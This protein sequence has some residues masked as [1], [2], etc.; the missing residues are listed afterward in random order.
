MAKIENAIPAWPGWETVRLIG[1]GSFGAVYEIRK[2]VLGDTE[3]CALKHLSIPRDESE[4]LELRLEGQDGESITRTFTNQARSIVSEY[5][6]MMQLNNCLGSL[7]MNGR[8][9]LCHA[10]NALVCPARRFARHT[11]TCRLYRCD[12]DDDQT[13]S[14][15]SSRSVVVQCRLIDKAFLVEY[16]GVHCRYDQSV[17]DVN[18][19]DSVG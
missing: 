7:F 11:D 1:R 13:E 17:L 8:G 14:A 6:L 9:K 18:G 10:R 16:T 12:F 2:T 4:I 15:G 5:K 19:T 3:R